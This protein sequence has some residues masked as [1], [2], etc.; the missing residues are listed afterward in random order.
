[1]LTSL[2]NLLDKTSPELG[3]EILAI[4]TGVPNS[5]Y[6][7][8]FAELDKDKSF[9]LKLSRSWK[10]TQVAL[11]FDS[12]AGEMITYLCSQ[13]IDRRSQIE[14][15]IEQN[16]GKYSLFLLEIDGKPFFINSLDPSLQHDLKFEV[17]ILASESSIQFGLLSMQEES[18]LKFSLT[19]FSELLPRLETG[20]RGPDEVVGFPEGAS[21]QVL[22]NRYERDPRNRRA[23]IDLHGRTCMAC[24]FN[25]RD[26]YGDLG[27]DYIVVH[28]VTP[29]SVIGE[30]YIV[31]PV[32]D[33]VTICANCH[34][35]VH[36]TNP[37]LTVDE[38]K[39]ILELK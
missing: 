13:L 31:D 3:L 22:V 26:N 25:F 30:N 27:D 32:T 10:T 23:A 17:E 19:F 16:L 35:M 4:E 15:L 38:L 12:F 7:L 2:S 36:R 21:S 6:E 33:L 20:Y 28:H 37:P 34:A 14:K 5:P 29:V 24:G 9:A 1:M 39:K 8:R 18:L 11:I